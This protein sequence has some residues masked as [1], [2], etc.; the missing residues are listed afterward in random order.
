M[1]RAVA[2]SFVVERGALLERYAVTRQ[3]TLPFDVTSLHVNIACVTFFSYLPTS[4]A[5]ISLA[6]GGLLPTYPRGW[7][8]LTSELPTYPPRRY[9]K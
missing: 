3:H 9:D 4:T 5:L 6:F 8:V 7:S 1:P 2:Y